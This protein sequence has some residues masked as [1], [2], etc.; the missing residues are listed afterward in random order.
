[1]VSLDLFTSNNI[2]QKYIQAFINTNS[3]YFIDTIKKVENFK[4]GLCYT[5]YLWDCLKSCTVISE[6]K[7]EDILEEKK[8]IYVMWDIHS[9]EKIFIPNYWKYPKMSVL[10][11]DRWTKKINEELPEDIY[12][13]DDS[14]SWSIIFT[15]E[16]NAKGRRYCLNVL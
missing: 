3:H 10:L 16:T 8:D 9:C 13:F 4:D 6:K 7:A 2:R 11:V 12:F 15:H 1:M 14:F 5:G